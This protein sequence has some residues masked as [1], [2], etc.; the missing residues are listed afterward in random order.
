MSFYA[1]KGVLLNSY[2]FSIVTENTVLKHLNK[3]GINK[4]TGLDGIPSRFVRDS[5]SLIACPLT[6]VVNLSIIQGVVPD[7][8]KLA[9]VV[10]LYKKSDK[11]DV[12]NYRPVS[13]LS[14]ISKV[15][16][17]VIYD[18]FDAY[19]TEKKL[20]YKF[21]SGFRR[22]FSTDTC[23]IHL[24]DYIRFQMDKGN[25]VGMVLLDLQKA[26]DTVDHDIL[27]MKLESLGLSSDAIR[28]FRSYV[29]GR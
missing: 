25:F 2:S 10:P 12:S 20:L 1:V 8:L 21:Q 18:Q 14:I 29:S 11:T 3:L 16:E 23:L 28:W 19:L 15:F 6:H 27:L 4:A 24:S 5:A 26:F 7:D 17:R 22:D 9:R 13:I